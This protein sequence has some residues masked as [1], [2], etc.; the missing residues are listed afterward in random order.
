MS[1]FNALIFVCLSSCISPLIFAHYNMAAH[2]SILS[3]FCNYTIKVLK[4]VLCATSP[5]SGNP[6]SITELITSPSIW[7]IFF[8]LFFLFTCSS[9]GQSKVLSFLVLKSYQ[10][11]LNPH[12]ASYFHFRRCLQRLVTIADAILYAFIACIND[13]ISYVAHQVK[14][15]DQMTMTG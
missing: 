15:L 3:L 12:V 4:W 11:L 2:F 5:Y 6:F 9:N 10:R 14:T 1:F 13:F 8:G 7:V